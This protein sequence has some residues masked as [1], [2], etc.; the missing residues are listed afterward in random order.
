MKW[1]V[2]SATVARRKDV[3]ETFFDDDDVAEEDWRRYKT[4]H[5]SMH[6]ASIRY[7]GSSKTL[8][9]SPRD[10]RRQFYFYSKL[11][12][13][14]V[15]PYIGRLA[16]YALRSEWIIELDAL[17]VCLEM[18]FSIVWIFIIFYLF[19][20]TIRYRRLLQSCW[21]QFERQIKI[22]IRWSSVRSVSKLIL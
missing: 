16:R 2:L 3:L 18:N 1:V 10:G 20:K 21:L 4:T 19:K 6:Y 5:S 14:V 7:L 8:L 12:F 11:Y 15:I 22:K 13:F 9:L 17:Q